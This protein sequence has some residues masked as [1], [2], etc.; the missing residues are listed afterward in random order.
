[1]DHAEGSAA[2]LHHVAPMLRPCWDWGQV[3]AFLGACCHDRAMWGHGRWWGNL[4]AKARRQ[5]TL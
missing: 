3:G 4:F 2:I 5:K 1:M